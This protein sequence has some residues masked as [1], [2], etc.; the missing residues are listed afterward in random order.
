MSAG[1]V[2]EEPRPSSLPA[3]MAGFTSSIVFLAVLGI[4]LAAAGPN[5]LALPEDVAATW[6]AVVYGLP[7]LP[8]LVLSIRYRMPRGI[9]RGRRDRLRD[10]R[11]RRHSKARQLDPDS[12]RPGPDRGSRDA[13]PD[14]PV[15][16]DERIL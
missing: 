4:M 1:G 14:R 7:M 15:H 2:R 9:D 10:R 5:G 13:V 8:A 3:L 6:I 16:F 12:D 11:V